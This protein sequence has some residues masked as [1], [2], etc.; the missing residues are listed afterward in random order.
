MTELNGYQLYINE[1]AENESELTL[2]KFK[3]MIN[4]IPNTNEKGNH[5]E[6]S[7]VKGRNDALC[8]QIKIPEHKI[9]KDNNY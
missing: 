2:E 9:T 5:K 7:I 6:V 4:D 1:W 3:E 8:L